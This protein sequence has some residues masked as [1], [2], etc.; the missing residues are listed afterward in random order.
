MK[1][2]KNQNAEAE[3]EEVE[4]GC[5]PWLLNDISPKIRKIAHYSARKHN[6]KENASFFT[7]SVLA[8]IICSCLW[9]GGFGVFAHYCAAVDDEKRPGE[10]CE[11]LSSFSVSVSSPQLS[12]PPIA[13]GYEAI[14]QEFLNGTLIY[15]DPQSGN[16]ITLPIRDL[17]NPLEG[18]FDLSCCG[19]TG[20]YL[21]IST[22]YRKKKESENEDKVEIW[23]TPRFLIEKE[24]ETTA[25]HFQ[26]IFGDWKPNVP[27]GIFWTWGTWDNLTWYDYLTT[28]DNNEIKKRNLYEKH[29]LA[30][31]YNMIITL[32]VQLRTTAYSAYNNPMKRFHIQF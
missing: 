27:V 21:S 9:I 11:N 10:H 12:I 28:E 19:D 24:L 30:R 25:K 6:V 5:K 8:K 31:A 1:K 15:T 7:S 17:T 32:Y 18:T 26:E 14:Y 29:R 13:Q 23:I 22:G 4:E 2:K 16:K 3:Q 20:K